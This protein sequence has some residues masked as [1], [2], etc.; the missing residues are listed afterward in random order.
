MHH[1][2]EKPVFRYWSIVV[3]ATFVLAGLAQPLISIRARVAPLL[4]LTGE[5]QAKAS[6]PQ[7]QPNNSMAPT[8][9]RL[10]SFDARSYDG[11]RLIEWR[12][13]YESDNR[14]FRLYRDEYGKPALST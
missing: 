5:A 8:T 10:E 13:G 2:S 7:P 1:I 11:G 9:A 6:K 14:G 4:Y 3:I 12:T